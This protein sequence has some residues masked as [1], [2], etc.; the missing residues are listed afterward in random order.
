M[1]AVNDDAVKST[2]FNLVSP[3]E[4]HGPGSVVISNNL[5]SVFVRLRDLIIEE[6][7]LVVLDFNSHTAN[8]NFILDN[9]SVYI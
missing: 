3:N 2:L 7:G 5:D 8:L 9:I 1:R 6:F 4:R